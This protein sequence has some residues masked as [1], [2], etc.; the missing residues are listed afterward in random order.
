MLNKFIKWMLLNSHFIFHL[1]I[2]ESLLF[3]ADWKSN[4]ALYVCISIFLVLF[5]CIC[6]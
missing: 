4:L 2:L 3:I 1:H 6:L 5:T